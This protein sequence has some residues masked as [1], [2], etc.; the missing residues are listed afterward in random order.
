MRTPWEKYAVDDT[1]G[2]VPLLDALLLSKDCEGL[3]FLM[4]TVQG[5]GFNVNCSD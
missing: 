1:K 4:F 3:G 5:L 2:P